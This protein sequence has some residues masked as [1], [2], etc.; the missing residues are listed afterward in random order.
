MTGEEAQLRA[1][2]LWV[3]AAAAL[4]RRAP[5]GRYRAAHALGRFADAPFLMPLPA[6]L[7]G[8][9]FHCDLRDTVA[10]EA[11]FTGRYE[12]QETQIAA[13]VLR[14]GMTAVDVGA[15]WGYFTLAAAHWVG[16]AGRVVA[17]EPEPRL[18]A[19]LAANL[20]RNDLRQVTARQI[21]IA[22]CAGRLKLRA[23]DPIEGNWGTSHLNDAGEIE[24]DAAALDDRLDRE[25]VDTVDLLKIDVE[26]AEA[27]VLRGMSRGLAARRY[28]HVLLECHPHAL[29]ARSQTVAD[30]IDPLVKAGYRAHV[31]AHTP[32]VHRRAAVRTLPTN[33]LLLPY[34]PGARLP[35]AWPHF[36]LTAPGVP[37]LA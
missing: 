28:R 7:G 25:R 12:P 5:A 26:G 16:T 19:M 32:D 6:S 15:N 29:D 17:F 37:D 4:I 21:A 30:C 18:F 1:A 14:S 33:E 27:D 36:F 20:S 9:T 34:I 2:P 11:C 3:R 13:R 23:F 22:A 24:C 10:R 31:I 8:Y 35:G